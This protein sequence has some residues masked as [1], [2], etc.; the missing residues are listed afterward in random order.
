MTS[1]REK[2]HRGELIKSKGGNTTR[3]ELRIQK[4]KEQKAMKPFT[5]TANG[6]FHLEEN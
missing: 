6:F 1:T 3:Q 2:E 4:Y 5:Q